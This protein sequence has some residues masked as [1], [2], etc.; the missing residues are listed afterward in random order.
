MTKDELEVI[1]E[2]ITAQREILLNALDEL[3][4]TESD[5]TGSHSEEKPKE[6][7]NITNFD[8]KKVMHDAISSGRIKKAL[9][10]I[11]DGMDLSKVA[12]KSLSDIIDKTKDKLK[13]NIDEVTG[14]MGMPIMTDMWLP[15]LISL[16]Q[17]HEFQHLLANVFVQLVK[18]G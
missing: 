15:M 2:E 10:K 4:K 5:L 6:G 7:Q 17:T 11:S 18:D 13:G 14:P 1:L 3:E 8:F 9:E 12:L 16:L